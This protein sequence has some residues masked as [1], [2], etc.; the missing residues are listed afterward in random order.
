[1]QPQRLI[2]IDG[3]DR[4]GKSTQV[5]LLRNALTHAYG[6]FAKAVKIPAEGWT[7]NVIYW[8][9]RNGL[10]KRL[11]NVFQL[12]QFVNKFVFQRG[13][14]EH[15][16]DFYDYIILD[17]WSLSAIVYGD[18]TGVNPRFNR[19][20]TDHLVKPDITIVLTGKPF[21]APDA[22][23]SHE[24]DRQLQATVKLGY[25]RWA[26]ENP[27]DHVPVDN[28]GTP[29]EVCQRILDA[30]VLRGIVVPL[31]PIEDWSPFEVNDE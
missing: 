14:L 18:A 3:P 23:D 1:M 21:A 20:L 11:P 27:V 15:L 2:C 17:R 6:P 12:I 30:L 26:E 13:R 31:D 22:D 10:A 4:H 19:F 29:D 25:E 28:S 16:R 9:L 5:Q 24:A 7:S 8:M